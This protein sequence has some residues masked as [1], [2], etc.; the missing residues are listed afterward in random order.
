MIKWNI[1]FAMVFFSR[2]V[3]AGIY[4]D[5]Y[6]GESY[7]PNSEMVEKC[8][9]ELLRDSNNVVYDVSLDGYG[10]KWDRKTQSETV[11]KMSFCFSE[12][13]ER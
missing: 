6:Q 13:D 3:C 4:R 11:A 8:T 5:I 10:I 1:I 2:I 9:L 12:N 7:L